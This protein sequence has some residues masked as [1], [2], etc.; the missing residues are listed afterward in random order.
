MWQRHSARARGSTALKRPRPSPTPR[1]WSASS[2]RWLGERPSGQN[3]GK[4][5]T[6]M[7]TPTTSSSG[8]ADFVLKYQQ[9]FTKNYVALFP[10]IIGLLL[11]SL[12]GRRGLWYSFK[13]HCQSSLSSLKV[14]RSKLALWWPR[15]L[16]SWDRG[17]IRSLHFRQGKRTKLKCKRKVYNFLINAVSP[18][19]T[20]DMLERGRKASLSSG[21]L[22]YRKL[23][24]LNHSSGH[25]EVRTSKNILESIPFYWFFGHVVYRLV[26]FQIWVMP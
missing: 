14:R 16:K 20:T 18:Q 11:S 23:Q 21:R 19:E 17:Q 24:D 26:K 3:W 10:N 13:R 1:L 4:T 5:G 12:F 9:Q 25:V 15:S 6:K 7:L 22:E 2:C 8:W